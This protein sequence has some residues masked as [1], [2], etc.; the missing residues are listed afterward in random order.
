MLNPDRKWS[1][2]TANTPIQAYIPEGD[3]PAYDLTSLAD[4]FKTD[5]GTIKHN[6]TPHYERY[7]KD[8]L[9]A[10]NIRMLEIG[11]GNGCSIKM[12]DHWSSHRWWVEGVDIRPEC[13]N[14]YGVSG[15]IRI[16]TADATK[17]LIPGPWNIIID[18]GS[19][20]PHDMWQTFSL[21][22]DSLSPGGFYCIEDWRPTYKNREMRMGMVDQIM[23]GV[24]IGAMEYVH[25][26]P[27]LMIIR[28]ADGQA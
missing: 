18:D 28:K 8:L 12:W 4:H 25:Y 7:F 21:Y 13:A 22:W 15:W 27:E 11:V 20:D 10:P 3:P 19:H 1:T 16:H 24:D 14:L 6:Y 2:V 5:K 17:T 9:Y 23:R 26:Y